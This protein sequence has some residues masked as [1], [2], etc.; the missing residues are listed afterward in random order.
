MKQLHWPKAPKIPHPQG[1]RSDRLIP[2]PQNTILPEAFSIHKDPIASC[3]KKLC[4]MHV[5]KPINRGRRSSILTMIYPTLR[6]V[7][8]QFPS[9][10]PT[11]Q[12]NRPSRKQLL[13]I[14]PRVLLSLYYLVTSLHW[15][16]E[17]GEENIEG[18]SCPIS[19]FTLARNPSQLDTTDEFLINV[20]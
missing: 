19:S 18:V 17:I 15:K 2:H 1:H 3:P 7:S 4:P 13:H 9:S 20:V 8:M 14:K 6:G 5:L 12:K 16:V 10:S 11:G